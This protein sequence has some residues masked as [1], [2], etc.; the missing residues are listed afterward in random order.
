MSEAQGKLLSNGRGQSTVISPFSSARPHASASDNHR[1]A[2]RSAV[3]CNSA[4]FLSSRPLAPSVQRHLAPERAKTQRSQP[5]PVLHR[6]A[7]VTVT[8]NE[9][10]NR[11]K[12]YNF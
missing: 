7:T 5:V 2:C 6:A 8:T 4:Y 11:L 1:S 9:A 12:N 3:P 10:F